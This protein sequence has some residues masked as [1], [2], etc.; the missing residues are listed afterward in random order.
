M[1]IYSLDQIVAIAK[2]TSPIYKNLYRDIEPGS[3]LCSLPVL[4]NE[5]LM[6][7][8][9]AK[10]PDFV[11]AEGNTHG[12]IFESSAS[13]GKPKVTIWGQGEWS[14]SMQ[15]LATYH[16]KNKLLRNGDRV[17]NL[18]STPYLSY[19]I[20]H[21]VVE[22]F[23]GSISE[24][25]IGCEMPFYD[26]NASIEK[27]DCNVIAA[28]NSTVLGLAWNLLENGEINTTIER[29]LAG[30]ELLY[31]KQLDLIHRAF[32]NATLVSF[33][34]GT[35][36]SGIIGY[37]TLSDT[38]NI[39][40]PFPEASIVE[41]LDI[42]TGEPITLPN[43]IGKCVV[44]SLLRVAAPA[45]RID[46][47]DYARWCESDDD[48]LQFQLIGRRFPFQHQ[49]E[50]IS[51][52]ETDVWNVILDLSNKVPLT[53]FQMEIHTN[54]LDIVISLLDENSVSYE[55]LKKTVLESISYY[56]PELLTSNFEI[57]LRLV[58]FAEFLE[59]TRRKGR[60]IMDCR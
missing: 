16:W 37:S 47:G 52:S 49:F 27:Y 40:R 33:L 45:L 19:R 36:E 24:I 56:I 48:D 2:Y 46:T 8:V 32:P 25:P 21:S 50:K 9:H 54:Q 38:P 30:G 26:L 11:F 31:G 1:N 42:D 20:V 3:P 55:L 43:V 59:S 39:F 13:T 14:T 23:P 7:I 53:K 57:V 6:D 34:F 4:S 51:L 60:L 18:C 35:T 15:L 29:I 41:I 44:T 10:N 58:S 5:L 22:N 17:G 28:I 12:L